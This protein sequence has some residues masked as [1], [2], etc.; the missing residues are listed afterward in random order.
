MITIKT[1]RGMII[2]TGPLG[3]P[4]KVFSTSKKLH[5]E[6]QTSYYGAYGH[7]ANWN[8]ALEADAVAV[9]AQL[10]RNPRITRGSVE[11]LDIPE[12]AIP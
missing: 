10:T 6:I 5:S 1:E 9:A 12:G 2:K 7:Q 8:R 4:G 3:K 11:P